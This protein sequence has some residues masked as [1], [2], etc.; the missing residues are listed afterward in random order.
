MDIA[1]GEGRGAGGKD[2]LVHSGPRVVHHHRV[3]RP[4][5][6][7]HV[8]RERTGEHTDSEVLDRAA[9]LVA[10]RLVQ[11]RTRKVR[12]TTVQCQRQA[13]ARA[14]AEVAKRP[15]GRRRIDTGARHVRR[16]RRRGARAQIPAQ[17]DRAVRHIEHSLVNG[18]PRVAHHHGVDRSKLRRHVR[19]ER[20]GEHTDSKVLDRAAKLV[21]GRLAGRG[22]RKVRRTTV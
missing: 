15:T 22:T 12:R 19:R 2:S 17:G 4:K 18:G 10:G 6:R 16:A 20:T 7:R 21:A 13:V 9:K 3:D 5:L 1:Q 11:R 14:V 8:R